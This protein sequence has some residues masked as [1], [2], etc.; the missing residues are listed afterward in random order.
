M[1]TTHTI[2]ADYPLAGSEDGL[3]V[4]IRFDYEPISKLK[5]SITFRSVMPLVGPLPAI[6]R[7][8]IKEWAEGWLDHEDGYNRAWDKA[9]DDT[10]RQRESARDMGMIRS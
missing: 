8:A 4:E 10:E 3:P 2:T 9:A 6:I 7:D 5:P 1:R